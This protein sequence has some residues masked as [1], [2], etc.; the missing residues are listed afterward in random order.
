MHVKLNVS[1]PLSLTH[2][3]GGA[4]RTTRT[5]S[6]L[7]NTLRTPHRDRQDDT[8]GKFTLN[9]DTMRK[10]QLEREAAHSVRFGD[11]DYRPF[12]ILKTHI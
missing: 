2:A 1:R 8:L 4:R 12:A 6:T 10:R 3:G 5:L 11:E 9:C 7:Y